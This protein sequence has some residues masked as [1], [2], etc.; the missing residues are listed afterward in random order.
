M[1]RELPKLHARLMEEANNA[2]ITYRSIYPIQLPKYDFDRQG[3][4]LHFG[5]ALRGAIL[6]KG[7]GE[8][9]IS[10]NPDQAEKFKKDCMGNRL[11]C[12]LH[13]ETIFQV[14]SAK[15]DYDWLYAHVKR[16]RIYMKS[17]IAPGKETI[18]SKLLIENTVSKIRANPAFGIDEG[19]PDTQDSE[20]SIEITF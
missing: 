2:P 9:F 6:N 8:G 19:D 15:G 11:N 20:N 4:V 3:Y 10:M 12:V 7:E 14:V 18:L 17:V 16:S 13:L 1:R 5:V